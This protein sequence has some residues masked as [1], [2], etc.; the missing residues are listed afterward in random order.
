[1]GSHILSIIGNHR[2]AGPMTGTARNRRRHLLT[3]ALAR[4]GDA[5]I[6]HIRVLF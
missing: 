3:W 1:M 2:R 4:L 6:N 5:A